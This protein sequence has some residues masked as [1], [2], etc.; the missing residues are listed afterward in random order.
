MTAIH[1]LLSSRIELDFVEEWVDYHLSFGIDLIYIY[2]SGPKIFYDE[3][4]QWIS[5]R[6]QKRIIGERRP[7]LL[8]DFRS[9]EEIE[10]LFR[11]KL[12][13]NK[14]V[15]LQNIDVSDL[16][17]TKADYMKLQT[18]LNSS[19]L[20]KYCHD[21]VEWVFNI[22]GDEFLN[23][24]LNSLK[25]C[26][27]VSRVM[28]KQ[29]CHENRWTEKGEP[30]RI[31]DIP[32]LSSQFITIC[33]KNAVRPHDV[34]KWENVHYGVSLKEGKKQKWLDSLFFRHY[35]GHG[36]EEVAKILE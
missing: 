23:G 11:H 36:Y 5:E 35:R 14:Q 9:D 22:D 10:H 6:G 15:R 32:E 31:E 2:N 28:I 4:P 33:N 8:S 21:G 16:S 29:I 18:K 34:D 7:H 19:E 27:D 13:K 3:K 25:N 12:S 17:L 30:R 26:E 1:A 24:D 20:E